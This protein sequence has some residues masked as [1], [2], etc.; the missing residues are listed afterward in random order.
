[1][2]REAMKAGFENFIPDACLIN[3]YAVGRKLG[4]HQD[5]NEKDFAQP[6][7][8]I[9]IGLPAVFQ[10]F[11]ET[12]SE[13]KAEYTLQDGDVMVWGNSARLVYHG[14]KTIKTDPLNP[15]FKHRYNITFRKSQ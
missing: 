3:Q 9:S 12:R 13:V 14:I 8:S 10:I 5:K 7:V 2:P 11:G 4:S 15:N 6:I 1:A